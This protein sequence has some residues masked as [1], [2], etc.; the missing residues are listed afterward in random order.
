MSRGG[1]RA[2]KQ[3]GQE[4]ASKEADMRHPDRKVEV[5]YVQASDPSMT[6]KAGSSMHPLP[7]QLL[8]MLARAEAMDAARGFTV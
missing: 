5:K 1:G 6:S 2:K 8:A 3:L 7:A 4:A